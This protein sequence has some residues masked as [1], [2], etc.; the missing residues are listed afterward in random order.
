[1]FDTFPLGNARSWS[2]MG[3]LFLTL[4]LGAACDSDG[5]LGGGDVPDEAL[6]P[7]QP[8]NKDPSLEPF[9][10]PHA[11]IE[12]AETVRAGFLNGTWRVG[13]ADPNNRWVVDVSLVH[14]EGAPEVTGSYQMGDGAYD[15]EA[16]GL[17]HRSGR[18]D[19]GSW[20]NDTLTLRWTPTNDQGDTWTLTA[21]RQ[22]A[23]LSGQILNKKGALV[24]KVRVARPPG[25]EPVAQP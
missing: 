25:Y 6:I 15:G 5:G 1:M 21:T 7:A 18:V 20:Q 19:G 4:S 2:A 23:G 14:D 24:S 8:P 11:G 13:S 3:A 9:D 22:G 16:T 12:D 17:M 10:D